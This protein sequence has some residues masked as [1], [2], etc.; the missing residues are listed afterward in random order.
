[1][2]EKFNIDIS[3]INTKLKTS[4]LSTEERGRLQKEKKDLED[5]KGRILAGSNKIFNT[6]VENDFKTGG[7]LKT[8]SDELDVMF[9]SL[10]EYEKELEEHYAGTTTLNYDALKTL[11]EN[12]LIE[13]NDIKQAE[14][15]KSK[16]LSR[17]ESIYTSSS[18]QEYAEGGRVGLQQGGPPNSQGNSVEMPS[19]NLLRSK[20]PP[21]ISDEVVRLI[22][23][24]PQ[25]LAAF[26]EIETEQDVANFN[27]TFQTNLVI[28]SGA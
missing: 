11:K 3:E 24:S 10:Y 22:S 27:N 16:I 20:L 18:D 1:M 21:E 26:S 4:T 7:Q 14:F 9:Q 15:L 13:K 28:P 6:L 2:L 23:M 8:V 5:R 17:Y 12:I 25:A 19:Y